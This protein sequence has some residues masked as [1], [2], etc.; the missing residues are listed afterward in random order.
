MSKEIARFA[1]DVYRI[2]DP[3]TKTIIVNQII[4]HFEKC[5]NLEYLKIFK[6]N[7]DRNSKRKD[8]SKA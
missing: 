1:R 5:N 6:E 4:R 8:N 7:Y 3:V 2:R